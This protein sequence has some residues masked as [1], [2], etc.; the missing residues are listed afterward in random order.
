MA[1]T[2]IAA[3]SALAG[4]ASAQDQKKQ[5]GK[6]ADEAEEAN[7][8]EGKV[9]EIRA[10][11]ARAKQVQE[12]QQ[13][14]AAAEVQGQAQGGESSSTAGVVSST[15]TQAAANIGEINTN[16]AGARGVRNKQQNIFDIN[17]KSEQRAA[18]VRTFQSG[19]DFA[20]PFFQEEA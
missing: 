9:E 4:L 12:A 3:V 1:V 5:A 15:G 10:R 13:R 16:L 6:A 18:N 7:K 11:N 2:S 19:L 20:S 17:S 14:Q 8:I